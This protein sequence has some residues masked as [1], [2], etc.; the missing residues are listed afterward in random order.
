MRERGGR[1]R[2]AVLAGVALAHVAVVQL[3]T[4]AMA[5]KTPAPQRSRAI[6]VVLKPM[7]VQRVPPPPVSPE[8]PRWVPPLRMLPIPVVPEIAP[9]AESPPGESAD[10][11]ARRADGPGAMAQAPGTAASGALNLRPSKQALMGGFANPAVV[12]P[13]ANS[14]RPTAEERMAMAIN[15]DI[16]LK[17]ERLPDGSERRSWSK[18]IMVMPAIGNQPSTILPSGSLAGKAIRVCG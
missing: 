17:V 9:A 18:Y 6:E 7:E 15:P 16:C 4:M 8:E 1:R 11:V 14:P 2:L 3:W 13:R 12:D 5:R 10:G